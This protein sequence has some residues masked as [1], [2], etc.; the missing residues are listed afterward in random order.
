LKIIVIKSKNKLLPKTMK[1]NN[2]KL[3][4]Y[5]DE[6]LLLKDNVWFNG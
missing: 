6:N 1:V 2:F 4:I 3:I 5:L